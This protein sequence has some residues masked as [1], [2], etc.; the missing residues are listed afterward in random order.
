MATYPATCFC[1][2]LIC[3]CI[4]LTTSPSP[5][6]AGVRAPSAPLLIGAICAVAKLNTIVGILAIMLLYKVVK[7]LAIC[8][9][10]GMVSMVEKT[11]V[12]FGML[13][14]LGR[15]TLLS[16]DVSGKPLIG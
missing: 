4:G 9:R 1:K 12:K 6:R 13:L 11:L 15:E 16:D 2:S 3:A 14:V 8:P 10:L 5:L 7:L